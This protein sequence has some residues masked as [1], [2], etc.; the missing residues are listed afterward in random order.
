MN[1]IGFFARSYADAL[2]VALSPNTGTRGQTRP[3]VASLASRA[4]AERLTAANDG[5]LPRAA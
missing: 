3:A 5:D 1:I 4:A 2:S